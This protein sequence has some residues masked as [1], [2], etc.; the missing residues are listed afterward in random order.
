MTIGLSHPLA[1]AG[2]NSQAAG[3]QTAGVQ[4]GESSDGSGGY[5]LSVSYRILSADG[6]SPVL[7]GGEWQQIEAGGTISLGQDGSYIVEARTEDSDG[8]VA[9]SRSG[10]ITIDS[11]GPVIDVNGVADGSVLS[12]APLISIV[13]RDTLYKAGSLRAVVTGPDGREAASGGLVSEDAQSA[14]FVFSPFENSRESDG[15]YSLTVTAED[16]AGNAAERT[17]IFTLDRYGSLYRI[18]GDTAREME[19]YI[20]QQAFPV[21]LVEENPAE[22]TSRRVLLQ[23]EDGQT[24]LVP[25]RDY[26]VTVVQEGGKTRYQYRISPSVFSGDGVYKVM[27]LSVDSAGN[28]ADSSS[29]NAVVSFA[30]DTTGPEC[31]ISGI[32]S[33]GR[34]QADSLT[35]AVEVRDNIALSSAAVYVNGQK[36]QE[37]QAQEISSL[38][39]VLKVTLTSSSG[40]QRLQIRAVDQAGNVSWSPEIPFLLSPAPDIQEAEDYRKTGPSAEEI[41]KTEKRSPGTENL[42]GRYSDAEEQRLMQLYLRNQSGQQDSGAD[43]TLIAGAPRDGVSSE[44]GS[45]AS[46][47]DDTGWD[48]P[49]AFLK[50]AEERESQGVRI[51]STHSPYPAAGEQQDRRRGSMSILAMTVLLTALSAAGLWLLLHNTAGDGSAFR[52]RRRQK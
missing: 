45:G 41:D 52:H 33:G 29:Q 22:I 16:L 37:Y 2:A 17:M 46:G 44:S 42:Y 25:G 34:Y 47:D 21:I 7:H 5:S 14:S 26:T 49:P 20:H 8:N 18:G 32:E 11:T 1:G 15:Q 10:R 31:L 40:W 13:C 6:L 4:T 28:T 3:S 24:E 51:A 19:T 12:A 23:T 38:G 36:I 50:R 9:Y 35:A 30:I 48:P 43:V 39:G 27:V